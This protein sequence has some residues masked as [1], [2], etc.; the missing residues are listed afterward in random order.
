MSRKK[1]SMRTL[2]KA[3]ILTRILVAVGKRARIYLD[4]PKKMQGLVSDAQT[5]ADA[6]ER[7]GTMASVT[8][9]YL[10]SMGR[11]AR[12]YAT[13]R[14]RKVPWGTVLG[15]TAAVLYFVL[16]LDFIPDILMGVGL[17]DDAALIAFVA[18]RVKRDLETFTAWERARKAGTHTPAARTIDGQALP[19]RDESLSESLQHGAVSG[20]AWGEQEEGIPVE[21]N[22]DGDSPELALETIEEAS[23]AILDAVE[24]AGVGRKSARHAEKAARKA[25]KAAK[26]AAK[27]KEKDE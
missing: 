7:A 19:V 3:A 24:E 26:K 8:V 2:G 11:M 6:V 20:F 15:A 21:E 25:E 12:A 10:G 4:D 18:T 17:V 13:R 16:P 14:Y 9:S 27:A 1:R 5:R 22:A 23:A